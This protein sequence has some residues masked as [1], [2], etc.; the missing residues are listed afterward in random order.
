MRNKRPGREDT[1]THQVDVDPEHE[2]LARQSLQH[3]TRTRKHRELLLIDDN[4]SQEER[5][6]TPEERQLP[7]IDC[8]EIDDKIRFILRE[9]CRRTTGSNVEEQAI[10]CVMNTGEENTTITI[11]KK[12]M[13]LSKRGSML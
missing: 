13:K 7:L 1:C 11:Y 5:V 2:I 6:Q 12:N 4:V 10:T 9:C 8:R 3:R